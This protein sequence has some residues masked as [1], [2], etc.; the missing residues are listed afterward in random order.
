MN[1]LNKRLSVYTACAW[2]LTILALVFR[3]LA[4][5]FSYDE[6]I[7]YF[8]SGAPLPILYHIF[9]FLIAVLAFSAFFVFRKMEIPAAAV[10]AMRETSIAEKIASMVGALCML[11]V[12]VMTVMIYWV[13]A[14][15]PTLQITGLG[16]VTAALSIFFF[17]F[18]WIPS[19]RG[20]SMHIVLGL[21]FLFHF[22]YILCAAYFELY[23]PMN[24]P[25][26][27]LAQL[28]SI[29]AVFFLLS[30]LRF[31]LNA[32]RPARLLF[33]S[34]L[35]IG[36]TTVAVFSGEFFEVN[37]P[38]YTYVYRLYNVVFLALLVYASVRTI[39][40]HTLCAQAIRAERGGAPEEDAEEETEENSDK[41]T[42]EGANETAETPAVPSENAPTSEAPS[43]LPSDGA[44]DD[45][46]PTEVSAD[47][48]GE[49]RSDE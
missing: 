9:M 18:F 28:S 38:E 3:L 49:T 15:V 6:D 26:K 14:T 29:A 46:T 19:R 8:V 17:L 12:T 48:S 10:E 20:K 40:F 21:A 32:A 33:S 27:L 7:G 39:R 22:L 36:Y 23:T 34:T 16:L 35:A 2:V 4:R 43:D 13:D 1:P 47:P 31:F 24:S 5:L 37:L 11:G 45:P 42:D 41:D 25:V 44:S 30:D